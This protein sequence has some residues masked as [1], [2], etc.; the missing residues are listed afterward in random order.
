MSNG[1]QVLNISLLED[2]FFGV[3]KIPKY[4]DLKIAVRTE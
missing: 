1:N 4:V 2:C 3:F